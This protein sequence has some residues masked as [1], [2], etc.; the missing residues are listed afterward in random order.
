MIEI[1][2]SGLIGALIATI[3]T[4]GYTEYKDSRNKKVHIAREK[5]E[6]VYGPL[7]ALKKKIDT[8]SSSGYGFLLPSN[9]MEK[10]LIEKIIFHHYHL[11]DDELK[12][13]IFLILPEINRSDSDKVKLV[14]SKIDDKIKYY[15]VKN[16]RILG[17]K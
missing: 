11:I 12:E 4:I 14:Q 6:K 9:P 15:Y 3:I 13:D 10:E 7:V 5:L 1:L 16:K 17:L 8:A 2:L